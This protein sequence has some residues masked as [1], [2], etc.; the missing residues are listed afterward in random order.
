MY[1][2]YEEEREKWVGIARN[3]T[4][5]EGR[6]NKVAF[7]QEHPLPD[8]HIL[9]GLIPMPTDD[10]WSNEDA[11]WMSVED[12]DDLPCDLPT[13]EDM[14]L[15]DLMPRDNNNCTM[16]EYHHMLIDFDEIGTKVFQTLLS[17]TQR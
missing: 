3:L 14:M 2:R 17:L 7:L 4:A 12:E 15:M 9:D 1:R 13:A 5:N 10:G 11:E 8:P 16:S 6:A